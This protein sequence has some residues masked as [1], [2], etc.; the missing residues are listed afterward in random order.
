[1]DPNEVL[2]LFKTRRSIRKFKNIPVEQE[3]IDMCL[4]AAR[5]SPSAS[6]RQPWEFLIVKEENKRKELAQLA[7]YGKFVGESP[8]IFV[9][10]TKPDTHD[11]YHASDTAMA[12]LQFMLMAHSQGLATCW[13]AV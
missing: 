11:T 5:W 2:E 4:E 12:T 10:I 8:V 1:M 6:N 3:K 13:S 9:P 7:T